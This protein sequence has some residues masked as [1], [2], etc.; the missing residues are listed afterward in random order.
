MED[1]RIG[2]PGN[3]IW[4]R[5]ASRSAVASPWARVTN[6]DMSW[7]PSKFNCTAS[8]TGGDRA[9]VRVIQQDDKGNVRY[10]VGS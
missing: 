2:A 10:Q 5:V 8:T 6:R 1:E 4:N 9:T 3:V 7:L